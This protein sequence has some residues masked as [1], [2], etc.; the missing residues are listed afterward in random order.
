VSINLHTCVCVRVHFAAQFWFQPAESLVAWCSDHLM[1][2]ADISSSIKFKMLADTC[3]CH[4]PLVQN[5]CAIG[6]TNVPL[7][8]CMPGMATQLPDLCVSRFVLSPLPRVGCGYKNGPALLMSDGNDFV[9]AVET[10]T[11]SAGSQLPPEQDVLHNP[12]MLVVALCC[13][14]C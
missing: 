5:K 11:G 4:N 8:S 12:I 1:R 6:P 13:S 2:M 10:G 14:V 7:A 9:M 3:A